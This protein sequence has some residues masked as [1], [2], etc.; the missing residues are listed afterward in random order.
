MPRSRERRE[1]LP[2]SRELFPT[3]KVSSKGWVVIP[4]EIRDEMGLEP[5][6]TVQ[7]SVLPPLPNMRQ[8]KAL[9][10]LQIIRVPEDPVALTTGMFK[11][12]PGEPLM[13]WR[14]VEA[15]RREAAEEERK[16]R[17]SRR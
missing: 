3:G 6:D 13:T 8:D 4:K 16:I 10:V 17:A 11:R 14:L 12:K 2:P 9:N 7:F 5:G 15:R 1:K